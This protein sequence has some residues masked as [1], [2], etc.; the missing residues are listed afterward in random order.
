LRAGQQVPLNYYDSITIRIASS[1]QIKEWAKR[2]ACHCPPGRKDKCT[3]GEVKKPETINYRTFK[4]EPEGLFCEA[5]FGPQ[6]DWECSCGKYKRIKHKGIVCDRCGVEVT[7]KDVRRERMGYIQLAAPVSHIWFFKGLPSRIG[8]LLDMS[9]RDLEKVLYFESYIVIDPKD[10]P[11]EKKQLLSEDAY[12]K[13]KKSGVDFR[14]EMGAAV[15]KELLADIDLDAEIAQIK[16]DLENTNSKQKEKKYIKRLK[17]LTAVQKSGNRPEWTILDVIPVI[18]PE[19]RPL[20]PLDGGRFATSDLNDLYRRVINRNNRLKRLQELRA[21]DV[22]IR[23]EKRMLQEAVDAL[24]DNGRH[25]RIVRGPGNRPLKSLSDMLKG[26]PGRFRQNLLGKRVDYSGRSVIVVGPELKMNECGLPRKMALELFKPFI[27]RKLQ[28]KGYST[29]IKSAKKMAERATP[30]VWE[31]LEEVIKEHP[32]I[33]NRAPTLH[34]LGIQAFQPKLVDGKAIMIHPLVCTAFNADF[35]GDQMAVHVPLSTEAQIEAKL[36]MMASQNILK[37]AHG[38]PIAVPDLDIVLGCNYLT[39]VIESVGEDKPKKNSDSDN[40]AIMPIFANAEDV[41]YAHDSG[42]IKLHAPIRFRVNGDIIQ[43]TPGRVIFSQIVPEGLMFEDERLGKKISFVNKEMQA[44]DLEN[45]VAR[46]FD[47]HGNYQTAKFLDDLKQLGFKYATKAGL[48][49][50]IDDMVIPADKKDLIAEAQLEVQKVMNDYREGRIAD[51]ERY[52]KIV[53]IWDQLKKDLE[54]SLF[55]SLYEYTPEGAGVGFNSLYIMTDS[56]A[57]SKKEPINQIS[58]MRGLMGKP[59]GE[60]I[61][62]PIFANL[63]E[64]LTVLEYFISTHGARKGLADTAIK[65]ASSGYLTRKLVD[66]AQDVIVTEEDCGTPNSIV[67][68]SL[69]S[70]EEKNVLVSKIAGRVA[71]E[72]VLDPSTGDIIIKNNE[73]ITKEIAENIESI[74]IVSVR[75]RSPLT[76]ES[77]R[78]VCR[79]CYGADLSSWKLVHIGEAVGI[80]SAQSIGEP[81]TQLTMRTFHTGGAVSGAAVKSS[82]E[83]K[84]AGFVKFFGLTTVHRNDG[85]LVVTNRNGEISILSEKSDILFTFEPEK[86]EL[87][88][89]LD[90]LNSKEIPEVIRKTFNDRNLTLSLVDTLLFNGKE[91]GLKWWL[92]D[93]QKVYNIRLVDD[94]LDIHTGVRERHSAQYGATITIP[95][96]G[97]IETSETLM[98]WDPN[99]DSIL[100]EVFGRAKL[101]DVIDNVTMRIE[102]DETTSHSNRVIVEHKEENLHPRISILDDNGNNKVI[103]DKEI[104]SSEPL[105]PLSKI[106]PKFVDRLDQSGQIIKTKDS[107]NKEDTNE[108]LWK[109][110][111]DKK[112]VSESITSI[113]IEVLEHAKRWTIYTDHGHILDI[114]EEN[115]VLNVYTARY[116]KYDLSTGATISIDDGQEVN[117]GD[118][119]AKI[120]K[121]LSKQRDIVHGLPRVTELFEARKPKDFATITGIDGFVKFAGISRGTR[122]IKVIN[123][124]GDEKEYRIPRGKHLIVKDGD[125]VSAGNGLTDGPINPHDMLSVLGENSVQEYLVDEVQKVYRAAGENI[126]DKHVEIIVRQMMRK[127]RVVEPGDT[128][129]LVGDEVDK[130]AFRKENIQVV[131]NGGNAA[132]AEAILQGITKA[133]LS[134]ESFISAASFQQ[135]TNVLT[136][137][138]IAGKKDEMR[139]LKENVI[140]GRLIPAGSGASQYR[141]IGAKIIDEQLA[142]PASEDI[143]LEEKSAD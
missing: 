119:L 2:T 22:I 37:P 59:S 82:A 72:D 103:Y 8:L 13:L 75:V 132:T 97:T 6:K 30:E 86:K 43:T 136:T 9:H 3:C 113:R 96:S 4:P 114:R 135:T 92:V 36:L 98:E 108:D 68:T 45:I 19:L 54:K 28:E 27:I 125:W 111:M 142:L 101:E 128:E 61:E 95:D 52:N 74:G 91:K 35:D 109:E 18:P 29:T 39:K 134:T 47:K 78:G 120:P 133:S 44:M 20:V 115:D 34:R 80:I 100:T 17:L 106:D 26:K 60:I 5:I 126:N 141:Q 1:E 117:P 14:A 124:N 139:G 58:G 107:K 123:P 66:V 122:V 70:E 85:T 89:I 21:P 138:A 121:E 15:I 116:A 140:M 71:A 67:K 112:I 81:G 42:S 90:S 55:K 143:A 24:L 53:G 48:S 79:K 40:K 10:A 104:D 46:C 65:T 7:R 84:Q 83:A 57:R 11:L 88:D 62:T 130:F 12:G 99:N 41:I 129:F 73:E 87:N 50:C 127:V 33:L 77:E 118:V 69:G 64:G 76:C 102:I 51:S 25:G 105:E 38:D 16:E 137:A 32:V 56:G 110:L 131:E 93:D 49:I 31:A 94:H 23:N 63:R